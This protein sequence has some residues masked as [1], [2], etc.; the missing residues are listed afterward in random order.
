MS[1]NVQPFRFPILH[2]VLY[3]LRIEDGNAGAQ[4]RELLVGEQENDGVFMAVIRLSHVYTIRTQ[5]ATP[6]R[7]TR[8]LEC[9]KYIML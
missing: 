1:S 4:W 8:I 7:D 6:R 5:G 9:G 2:I 3:F